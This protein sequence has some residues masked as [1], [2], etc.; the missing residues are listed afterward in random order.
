VEGN[1]PAFGAHDDGQ[2]LCSALFL[3]VGGEPVLVVTR[4]LR[5]ILW[6]Q[7]LLRRGLHKFLISV[8]VQMLSSW[9]IDQGLRL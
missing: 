2:Q 3:L 6:E 4:W 8:E 9:L 7:E 5:K 1:G